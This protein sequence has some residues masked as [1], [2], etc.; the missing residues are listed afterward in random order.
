M[1]TVLACLQLVLNVASPGERRDHNHS[2]MLL[3]IQLSCQL[4]SIE[5]ICQLFFDGLYF[6]FFHPTSLP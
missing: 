4:A 1:Q 2:L 5:S 6:L 3:N